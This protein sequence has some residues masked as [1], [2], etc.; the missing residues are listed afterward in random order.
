MERA[1]LRSDKDPWSSGRKIYF[2]S[3][4]L[5]SWLKASGQRKEDC[6]KTQTNERHGDKGRARTPKVRGATELLGPLMLVG[7]LMLA[8]RPSFADSITFTTVALQ[9]SGFVSVPLA[10]R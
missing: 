1:G 9:N 6:M 4:L 3:P 7:V 10:V 2:I 8:V 5:I